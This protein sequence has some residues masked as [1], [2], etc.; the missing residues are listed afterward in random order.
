MIGD[1][2]SVLREGLDIAIAAISITLV[3]E[4]VELFLVL[5]ALQFQHIGLEFRTHFLEL[6]AFLLDALQFGDAPFVKSKIA[7]DVRKRL[8]LRDGGCRSI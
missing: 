7:V 3:H 6:A 1:N 2:A 8:R 4:A 5:G